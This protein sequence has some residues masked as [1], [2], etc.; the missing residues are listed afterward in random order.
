M[1][2]TR[3]MFPAGWTYL[4]RVMMVSLAFSVSACTASSQS[5]WTPSAHSPEGGH[6]GPMIQGNGNGG[7]GM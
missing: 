7:S 4:M 6:G 5:R 3:N 1:W 2:S